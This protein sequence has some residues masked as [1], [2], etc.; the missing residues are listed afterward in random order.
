MLLRYGKSFLICSL[1]TAAASI[2]AA[3]DISGNKGFFASFGGDYQYISQEYY[4]SILETANFDTIETWQLDQDEINDFIFRTNLGYDFRNL[5]NRLNILADFELSGDRL[6]GRSEGY[7]RLGGYDNNLKIFGKFESKSPSGDNENR[8]EEYTYY[9]TYLSGRKKLGKQVSLFFKSG[10]ELIA[11][12]GETEDAVADDGLA[13]FKVFP[14]YDYSLLTGWVG[15]D[16][17]LS[18]FT[19]EFSWRAGYGHRGVP[20]S[21]EAEYD[22]YRFDIEYNYFDFRGNINLQGEMEVRDYNQPQGRD[23]FSVFGFRGRY[24]RA[25]SDRF[26]AGLFLLSDVYRYENPDVVNRNYALIRGELKGT[27]SI[28]G[29][30]WGPLTRLEYRNEEAMENVD[31]ES[32]TGI[33]TQWEAGLHAEF[34][35]KKA[36]FFDGEATYGQRN[37]REEAGFLTSYDF[38]SV[39]FIA[40]YSLFKNISLSFM[41]DGSFESHQ[42]RENDTNLYLLSIGVNARI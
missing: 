11:F 26:E 1:I 20:D 7:F 37:Y 19:S 25:L 38:W 23:D 22:Q 33:Y 8:I 41:F 5:T 21:A 36:L 32:F 31:F 12:S 10:Y 15:G 42:V 39:S 35:N 17:S 6:L 28:N 13:T 9:Q 30:G 24:N 4:N 3:A 18:E 34:L 2:S 16:F 40:N 14:N 29:F 27:L